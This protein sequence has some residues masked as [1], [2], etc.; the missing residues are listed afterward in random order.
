MGP[1]RIT[2]VEFG[3]HDR[4]P[5]HHHDRPNIGVMLGGSFDLAF[6]RRGFACGQGTVFLEP[7]GDTHCNCMG[8]RGARVLAV[9]PAAALLAGGLDLSAFTR[10]T[11]R[12]DPQA[13]HLGGRIAR[14][15]RSGDRYARLMIEG[16][17]LELLA[18]AERH[19]D[20]EAVRVPP[21][22]LARIEARLCEETVLPARLTDLAS[23]AGVHPAHLARAF[24]A[25]HG[26]SLGRFL[27]ERRLEWA[28]RELQF[29]RRPL[30]V[31]ALDAGFADQSHFTRRFREYCGLTPAA[32]R[33]RGAGAIQDET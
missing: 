13:A 10:P 14:E 33:R 31:L 29:T 5:P 15:C 19:R 17:A 20:R 24:R 7:A 11:A 6:D 22:W 25:R 21:A 30:A 1:F 3:A 9:Q 2:E 16:L 18:V 23:E 4:I 26:R 28:A 32:Y 12:H 8:C 27:L